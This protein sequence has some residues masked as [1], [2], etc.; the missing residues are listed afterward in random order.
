MKEKYASITT[1]STGIIQRL[2]YEHPLYNYFDASDINVAVIGYTEITAKFI[3]TALELMQIEGY[4][5]QVLVLSE[6]PDAEKDYLST[7]P[8][9]N[10][11]ISINSTDEKDWGNI[12]FVTAKITKDTINELLIDDENT[13]Y[14]YFIVDNNDFSNNYLLAQEICECIELT[15]RKSCIAYVSDE[16]LDNNSLTPLTPDY[17]VEKLKEYKTL[18]QMAFNCHLTWNN[19]ENLNIQKLRAQF[20]QS[21]NFNSSLANVISIKYKLFSLG[22]I[23]SQDSNLYLIAQDFQN[24]LN[25][26]KNKINKLIQVEHQRWCINLCCNGWKTQRILKNCVNGSI[27]DKVNKFHPCLVHSDTKLHLNSSEWKQNNFRKWDEASSAELDKLDELDRVSVLIYRE[28]KKQADKNL[29]PSVDIDSIRALIKDY[30]VAI[31][32]FERY[33]NTIKGIA[34]KA[35]NRYVLQ[36]E[37]D[38]AKFKKSLSTLPSKTAKIINRHLENINTLFFPVFESQ[39]HVNYKL[40]D[41]ELVKAIPFILTYKTN[42]KIGV[43]LNISKYDN[44]N[45]MMFSNIATA[46]KLNPSRITYFIDCNQ[47]DKASLLTSLKYITKGFDIRNLQTYINLIIICKNKASLNEEPLADSLKNISKRIKS[48]KVIHYEKIRQL[49]E[50]LSL[51][52]TTRTFD[53][54]EE[55]NSS[56]YGLLSGMGFYDELPYY[57]FDSKNFNFTTCTGCEYFNYINL[58][59]SLKV[60][61]IVDLNE[62]NEF[63]ELPELQNDYMYFWK[64]YRDHEWCWKIMCKAIKEHCEQTDTILRFNT[65]LDTKNLK[66]FTYIIPQPCYASVNKIMIELKKNN[67]LG[68]KSKIKFH[69]TSSC[70][71]ELECSQ[72]TKEKFDKVFSN[73]YMLCD[74]A[75]VSFKKYKKEFCVKYD[76]LIVTNF[77]AT[78][79][80]PPFPNEDDKTRIID[81]LRT[82]ATKG[83]II[84]LKQ[85]PNGY[86]FC[87]SSNQIKHL[88]SNEG[89]LLEMYIYYSSLFSC[90]FDEVCSGAEIT[91]NKNVSNEFDLI[92]IKNFKCLIVEIKARTELNQDIYHKLANLTNKVGINAKAVLISDTL[93]KD[94]QD[95]TINEMQS[96]RGEEYNIITVHKKNDIDN[97]GKTL[98]DIWLN[99]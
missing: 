78:V 43:P 85:N 63:L 74:E 55:N 28:L 98:R 17:T 72:S 60:A 10:Q 61:D 73:P 87:F 48:I 77:N 76:S 47:V 30:P 66:N 24:C 26:D 37:H 67:I 81:N 38:K 65:I 49:K 29:Y 42:I 21:Y 91:W 34:T 89:L 4:K 23:W 82:F 53:A 27:K 70:T 15:N 94:Y 36:Y 90:F 45:D 41:A 33:V 54:I 83:Y 86:S 71:V 32:P 11:F 56:M 69:T 88:L 64:F 12:S 5:V 62:A 19:S 14:A 1:N 97:I 18:K 25:S 95:N 9:L 59:N 3:D 31:L 6:N 51:V 8:A 68:E 57:T 2:L 50:Q 52:L 13:K 39:R 40:Y 22:I 46:I 80:S 99:A 35:S 92:L 20:R 79:S 75:K 44:S 93:E 58:K 84:N 96:N 16:I 7:R